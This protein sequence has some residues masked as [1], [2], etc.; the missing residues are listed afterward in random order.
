[1][2][3]PIKNQILF[4]PFMTNGVTKGG[5]IV[6][7]SCQKESNKGEI[8][9]VGNGTSKTPMQFKGGEIAIRVKDWGE[10]IEHNGIRYY[11]MEQSAI[12]ATV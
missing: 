1:M 4:K 8:V 12:L 5:L 3:N 7:D 11:I 10:P 9:A 6:P 2:I